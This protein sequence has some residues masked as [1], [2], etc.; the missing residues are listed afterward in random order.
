MS[1]K[2]NFVSLPKNFRNDPVMKRREKMLS[3]LEQ[4][5]N[6]AQD[7]SYTIVQQRWVKD[8]NGV[9]QPVERHKQI[10]RWWLRNGM[11]DCLL[12][13]RYGSRVLE[14]QKGK[15]AIDTGG[16]ANLVAVIE[17]I[18]RMTK[19]GE[20]DGLLMDVQR[21]YPKKKAA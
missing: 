14:L 3:Q 10:K 12:I 18:M 1:A 8:E 4:Q 6:L 5:R 2:L 20:L 7:P 9:K 21:A 15:A 16:E 13:I 11:G 17:E 19:E